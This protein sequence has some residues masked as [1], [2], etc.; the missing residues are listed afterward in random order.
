MPQPSAGLVDT[1]AK[2]GIKVISAAT[3]SERTFFLDADGRVYS[4]SDVE[5]P[6]Q[7]LLEDLEMPVVQV[8]V[9]RGGRGAVLLDD[10]TVLSCNSEV[11]DFRKVELQEPA[12]EVACG[13]ENSLAITVHGVVIAFGQNE[14]EVMAMPG[15]RYHGEL[16][17]E[18]DDVYT[19]VRN[20]TGEL[21]ALD[22]SIYTGQFSHNRPHGHG[23]LSTVDGNHY[24]GL[25]RHGKRTEL[26]V[27]FHNGDEY[28]GPFEGFVPH[29][30]G[31]LESSNGDK[32]FGE[33]ENSKFH[34]YG[35]QK[36]LHG[37]KDEPGKWFE[38]YDGEMEAGKRHGFGFCTWPNCDNS[39]IQSKY[40]GEWV[41][42]EISGFGQMTYEAGH[43][44]S[45]NIYKGFFK[46]GVRHGHGT[47]SW[48]SGE[49]A[50]CFYDGE[51]SDGQMHGHGMYI[52][53]EGGVFEGGFEDGHRSQQGCLADS[54]GRLH[55]IQYE[56]VDEDQHHLGPHKTQ[57]TTIETQPTA[58]MHLE[59]VQA[60]KEQ[61][62]ADLVAAKK[63][64]QERIAVLTAAQDET[65]VAEKQKA[66]DA[67]ELKKATDDLR[68]TESKLE[69]AQRAV[70]TAQTARTT[71]ILQLQGQYETF[72][73]ANMDHEAGTLQM[74]IFDLEKKHKED[75]EVED[76]R[77][78]YAKQAH[79][80]A[81]KKHLA[82]RH[83]G[84]RSLKVAQ[85]LTDE[86]DYASK[87]LK[88]ARASVKRLNE[89]L[90]R[91]KLAIEIAEHWRNQEV[92]ELKT[93]VADRKLKSAIEELA[94]AEDRYNKA[95]K[96]QQQREDVY[97]DKE[98]ELAV[99]KQKLQEVEQEFEAAEEN[100]NKMKKES[101]QWF[102]NEN[103]AELEEAKHR[104]DCCQEMLQSRSEQVETLDR[105]V[106]RA[107]DSMNK[108]VHAS[109]YAMGPVDVLKKIVESHKATKAEAQAQIQRDGAAEA[110][111]RAQLEELQAIELTEVVSIKPP[112]QKAHSTPVAKSSHWAVVR[113]N[114]AEIVEKAKFTS[115]NDPCQ[116]SSDD[117]R[118]ALSEVCEQELAAMH[119]SLDDPVP[120]E[121]DQDIV[122]QWT[123]K[124]KYKYM[125]K[126]RARQVAAALNTKAS[127]MLGPVWDPVDPAVHSPRTS[128]APAQAAL[129]APPSPTASQMLIDL[130]IPVDQM[131]IKE[132]EAITKQAQRQVGHLVQEAN[133]L[134]LV[135]KQERSQLAPIIKDRRNEVQGWDQLSTAM[136]QEGEDT[137]RQ[138]VSDKG[139]TTVWSGNVAWIGLF[140]TKSLGVSVKRVEPKRPE[141]TLWNST[142]DKTF[143]EEAAN[144]KRYDDRIT[145][146]QLEAEKKEREREQESS[147]K[148][149]P[150]SPGLT[151]FQRKLEMSQQGRSPTQAKAQPPKEAILSPSEKERQ[152]LLTSYY[153]AT[154]IAPFHSNFTRQ[155]Q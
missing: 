18:A 46:Q 139:E 5:Y 33:F 85:T 6:V 88:T 97:N 111:L 75:K 79:D 76:S 23:Q 24:S 155:E 91:N 12:K 113:Q 144:N 64:V 53:A 25:W 87:R 7:P 27:K 35:S 99:A 31:I 102:S 153:E 141:P 34:G 100:V 74:E 103:E 68:L 127:S 8:A 39:R 131:D 1:L 92:E 151:E 37:E 59:T 134:P 101:N 50:G 84:D 140:V 86:S 21:Y 69:V 110:A 81:V 67:E 52:D 78:K 107:K 143:N 130:S 43:Q 136:Q 16:K 60:E 48:K 9:G 30:Y 11:D 36:L 132:V 96:G 90:A 58:I 137:V 51:W 93:K 106:E 152:H 123:L 63:D 150:P 20:G 77:L 142:F 15:N 112:P 133:M 4:T 62:E 128:P 40:Q 114:T 45:S 138:V 154:D 29:G 126:Y 42:D 121:A 71:Q 145:A 119:L 148:N 56:C 104:R 44:D 125:Y 72:A 89:L 105:Q 66:E 117:R 98:R 94:N 124:Y 118:D 32:Y 14:K 54:S 22:G 47:M 82:A 26:K 129:P 147:P 95:V 10:G 135:R 65:N 116:L 83:V 2:M 49:H 109:G 61:Y 13:L 17:E 19:Q 28:S 122:D 3:S 115:Q 120:E 108:A 57:A 73:L 80:E 146:M 55:I 70:N 149:N 41:Q 38:E